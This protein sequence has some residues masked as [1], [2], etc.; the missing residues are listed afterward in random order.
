MLGEC[1]LPRPMSRAAPLRFGG[2]VGRLRSGA[3]PGMVPQVQ[4]GALGAGSYA[5]LLFSPGARIKLLAKVR[6]RCVLCAV[7]KAGLSHAGSHVSAGAS[8][9]RKP[10]C[11]GACSSFPRF[12][13]ELWNCRKLP[14]L[15]TCVQL[16]KTLFFQITT[17]V[18][19]CWQ[20]CSPLCCGLPAPKQLL[21]HLGS[22]L[23]WAVQSR[24][25]GVQ[26]HVLDVCRWYA[27]T[28]LLWPCGV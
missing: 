8:F 14:V 25:V 7:L 4:R 13:S 26:G 22:H 3:V 28:Y 16:A 1:S 15:L 18:S 2:T 6:A 12:L 27:A 17:R 9:R 5:L 21:G 10:W 19:L 24:G 11:V 23:H 20:K